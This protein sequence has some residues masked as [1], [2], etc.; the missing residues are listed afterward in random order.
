MATNDELEAQLRAVTSR[1]LSLER[2]LRRYEFINPTLALS[3]DLIDLGQVPCAKIRATS[4]QTLTTGVSTVILMDTIAFN[5]LGEGAADLANDRIIIQRTGVY[6][7]V[8]TLIFDSSAV[9]TRRTVILDLNGVLVEESNKPPLG[10]ENG[11][12]LQL[13]RLRSLTLGDKLTLIGV[14]DSGGNLTTLALFQDPSL[15]VMLLAEI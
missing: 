1:T 7:V 8:G 4:N 10:G 13:I 3:R 9:G 14:Q 12:I 15:A 2:R 6:L 11:T 5:T